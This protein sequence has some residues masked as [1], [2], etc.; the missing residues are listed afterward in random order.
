MGGFVGKTV[1][2]FARASSYPRGRTAT[3]FRL[4][5][6][7]EVSILGIMGFAENGVNNKSISPSIFIFNPSAA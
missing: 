4:F 1:S 5:G 7:S 2:P 3:H 6:V